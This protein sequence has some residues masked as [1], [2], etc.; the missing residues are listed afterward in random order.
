MVAHQ[1]ESVN[2]PSGFQA[3]LCQGL[4]EILAINVVKVDVLAAVAA[5]HDV[6]HR[7]GIFDADLPRHEA[8]LARR[9]WR[10]KRKIGSD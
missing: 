2:L 6:I 9:A 7:A 1:T 4:E 5:A 10:V 8:T 3:S